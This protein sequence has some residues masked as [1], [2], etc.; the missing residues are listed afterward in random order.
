MCIRDSSYTPS[1]FTG[2]AH[3]RAVLLEKKSHS[4]SIRLDV[5]LAADVQELR[6]GVHVLVTTAGA[7]ED[8]LLALLEGGHELL[9]VRERVGGLERGDDTFHAG[10][11]DKGV[12]SL[13]VR[14]GVVLGAAKVLE[15]R[16]LGSDAGVVEARGDGVRLDDL[17]LLVLDEVGE[18]AVEDAGLAEGERRGVLCLLYTSPSP[19]DAT[20]SRMPSSA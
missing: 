6:G 3:A 12:E 17:A 11:A 20:L 4:H 18:G 1:L 15:E 14:H 8:H 9:E 2:E 19:R 13:L 5:H 16:V 10:H 7:V